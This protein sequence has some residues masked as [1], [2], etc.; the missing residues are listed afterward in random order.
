[1]GKIR[2]SRREAARPLLRS[3]GSRGG[4]CHSVPPEA[5]QSVTEGGYLALKKYHA[6]KK[7]TEWTDAGTELLVLAADD[8]NRVGIVKAHEQ[9]GR[10][11]KALSL[12]HI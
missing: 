9:R 2:L 6:N 10:T 4:H 1:M 5:P 11:E 12:I 8:P 3:S 7:H